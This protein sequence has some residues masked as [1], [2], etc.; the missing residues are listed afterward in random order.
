[1]GFY[2]NLVKRTEYG[3]RIHLKHKQD[4]FIKTFSRMIRDF[5][6]DLC[7]INPPGAARAICPTM[8]HPC[9]AGAQTATT[10]LHIMAIIMVKDLN[11]PKCVYRPPLFV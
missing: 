4:F 1:M 5:P 6:P 2:M 11:D 8:P 3:L 10:P 9:P 7:V